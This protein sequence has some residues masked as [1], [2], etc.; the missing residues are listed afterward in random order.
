MAAGRALKAVT[1]CQPYAELIRR[2]EKLVENR[3]WPT[4]Y[5]GLLLIHAGKSREWIDD[6]EEYRDDDPS[7]INYGIPVASMAF[8]AVISV[9]RLVDCV[10][11][12]VESWRKYPWLLKHPHA[13]GPW[14]WILEAAVPIGPW[15]WRGR[16]GLFDIDSDALDVRATEVIGA[17]P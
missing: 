9:V 16:L 6:E 12:Q 4:K 11:W 5:R 17:L 7:T 13:N 1:V 8:G 14:C 2:G 10:P 3:T 15:P